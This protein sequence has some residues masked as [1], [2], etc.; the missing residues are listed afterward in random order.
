MGRKFQSLQAK[1]GKLD[2]KTTS[3]ILRLDR[4][5]LDPATSLSIHYKEDLVERKEVFDLARNC[6][7]K[8]EAE[9][10]NKTQAKSTA[11]NKVLECQIPIMMAAIKIY[12]KV[13]SCTYNYLDM[14]DN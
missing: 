9:T 2:T 13:L 11:Q 14:V 1:C 10:S 6:Y 8:A 4:L 3:F 7:A 5:A 12:E